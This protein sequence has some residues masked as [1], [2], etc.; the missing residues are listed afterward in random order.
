VRS[1]RPRARGST[2]EVVSLSPSTG[3][4]R[5]IG[6]VERY[7]S[8]HLVTL[9][10]AVQRR[11]RSVVV[12]QLLVTA[13]LA[14]F[15]VLNL[16]VNMD[17]R[18]LIASD[19]PF[20]RAADAYLRY[21]PSLDDSL[22]I[23]VDA[24]S[25]EAARRAARTLAERLRA[26]PEA[27]SDVYVPGA[28]DFFQHRGLLYRDVDEL[29]DFIDH[30]SRLQPVLAELSRDASIANLA[31]L[32]QSGLD[33]ERARGAGGEE[34]A[35]VLDRMTEATVRVF[36]EYPLSISWEDLML[37]G[38]AFDPGAR[39]VVIAEPVLEFGQ[40]LAARRSIGHI[41]DTAAALSLTP[42]RGVRVRITGNPALNYEE[43]LGLAWDVG[44]AGLFSFALV[45]CTL[46][47][48]FRSLRLVAAAASTLLVGLVWTAAFAAASVGSLNV[49][50]IAFGVLFI[51]L[52]VDFGIHLGM[53]YA[54]AVHRGLASDDAMRDA[55]ERAGSSLVVCAITTAVGFFVFVPTDYLGVAEL[56]LISGVGMAV[57][58]AQTLTF[59][60]AVVALLFDRDARGFL[61]GTFDLHLT[62]PRAFSRH[63][64]A[65]V[66]L[67]VVLA[68]GA[69]WRLPEVRFNPNVIELRDPDT[70]S[71]QAMRDLMTGQGTTPWYIDVLAGNLEEADELG[72]RLRT[73]DEV[74]MVVTL[75]DYVPPDQDEKLEM[76]ADAALL[77]DAP[78]VVGAAP[79][80]PPVD[81]QVA[82]L[83]E[84]HQ[85]LDQDWLHRGDSSLVESAGLLRAELGRFLA[86]LE[87]E[88]NPASA[89][90]GLE[91]ILLGGFERQVERLRR[92]LEP[93]AITRAD[94]PTELVRRMVAA[95]GHARLQV[96]PTDD[97]DDGRQLGRFV[98]AVRVLAPEATGIA[99]NLVEFGRATT[100]SLRQALVSAFIAIA[101]L[102]LLFGSPIVDM[103]L[104]LIP[105]GLALTLTGACMTMLGITFNFANVVVLPL[106]LGIGVDSGIHLVHRSR[107]VRTGEASLLHTT[108]ARAVF[109]SAI[110]TIASFG[111]MASSG[112][113]G[114]ASMG[115][116]LVLGMIFTLAANLL[117]LPACIALR[118]Q[119]E[120]R[121][122]GA[123]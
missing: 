63:P 67:T 48:A 58:L 100:A 56:G 116:L 21:F 86:R 40:L 31:S 54:D 61:R 66:L 52:G 114:I 73:L 46:T 59:F 85:A 89:L 11:A 82:A 23:V 98:D 36:D 35:A 112:H 117:V 70:E 68:C 110:T 101:I 94:L 4:A 39:A 120:S 80:A 18:R 88:G 42:D 3:G 33:A 84:L 17:Y 102:M 75:N 28:G 32:I 93:P 6:R 76:L 25:G 95:D 38:S 65:V 53:Q 22:L 1:T 92:A 77:L 19:I 16:G 72:A 79:A 7:L 96:F 97:L 99:V 14:V 108:T 121:R 10:V 81:E 57:I 113:W 15:T 109:F 55:V 27:F 91:R 122:R 69:A 34:W 119:I 13:G 37:E 103:V 64:S 9:A 29:D 5:M 107:L 49:L 26:E 90:A 47:L 20:R 71:V 118:Q 105:V 8:D 83:R 104:V 123:T 2:G 60:P 87:A 115:I 30:L 43:M 12:L 44:V 41:R 106:L 50:S 51:G 78:R 62:P 74:D 111:S 24:S 45:T